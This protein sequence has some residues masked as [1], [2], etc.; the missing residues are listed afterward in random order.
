MHVSPFPQT[1][2]LL[3]SNEVLHCLVEVVDQEKPCSRLN[4]EDILGLLNHP[5]LTIASTNTQVVAYHADP[6]QQFCITL[7][8][9]KP[10]WTHENLSGLLNSEYRMLLA[11]KIILFDTFY[12]LSR[13]LMHDCDRK[14]KSSRP[15]FIN[16]AYHAGIQ[17]HSS[18]PAPDFL[19]MT[20]IKASWQ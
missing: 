16:T 3:V 8:S 19:K 12:I 6:S 18:F 13:I 7:T 9:I 14:R 2:D 10:S 1:V 15:K 17:L 20:E 11:L 4:L 5:T